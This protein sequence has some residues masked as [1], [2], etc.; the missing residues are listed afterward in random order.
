MSCN[1]RNNLGGRQPSVLYTVV[2]LKV[3]TSM[4]F[5]RDAWHAFLYFVHWTDL[6]LFKKLILVLCVIQLFIYL[7]SYLFIYLFIYLYVRY[8]RQPTKDRAMHARAKRV[9]KSSWSLLKD[10]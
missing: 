10:V 3:K 6:E 8:N 9:H 4:L 5:W 1:T 7:F 2:P